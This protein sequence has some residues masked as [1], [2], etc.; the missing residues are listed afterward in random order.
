MHKTPN[1]KTVQ[2]NSLRRLFVISYAFFAALLSNAFDPEQER[3]ALF[4]HSFGEAF[5]AR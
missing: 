4:H 3:F 1:K 5:V 2:A